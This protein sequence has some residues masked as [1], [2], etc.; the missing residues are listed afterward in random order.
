M[1]KHILM[2]TDGSRR[3]AKAIEQGIGFAECCAAPEIS[4][5]GLR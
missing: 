4:W 1:Y 3:F 2:P 5:I